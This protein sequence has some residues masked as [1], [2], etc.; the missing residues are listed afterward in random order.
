MCPTA[1]DGAAAEERSGG[2]RGSLGP[3][4]HG[5]R[6]AGDP[7][8]RSPRRRYGSNDAGRPHRPTLPWMA[9]RP[10]TTG[11]AGAAPRSA[12]LSPAVRINLLT[13]PGS[14]AP[15][16]HRLPFSFPTRVAPRFERVPPDLDPS[17]SRPAASRAPQAGPR[18]RRRG[19]AAPGLR[20]RPRP[21]SERIAIPRPPSPAGL[22]QVGSTHRPAV[23]G[24]RK[25]SAAA[26]A[27]R[28]PPARHRCAAGGGWSRS[29][30][31][32]CAGRAAKGIAR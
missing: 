5:R 31:R 20:H 22:P 25:R 28:P 1:G 3:R 2:D 24:V 7:P 32:P 10:T 19:G 30:R 14:P 23:T 17:A 15:A 29:P 12:A 4:R 11:E 27:A 18:T 13:L 16:S 9:R 6:V 26:F 8:G 21:H